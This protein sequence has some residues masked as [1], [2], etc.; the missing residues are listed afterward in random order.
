MPIKII[1]IVILIFAIINGLIFSLLNYFKVK[2]GFLGLNQVGF[3]IF[4][5]LLGTLMFPF[6]FY[7]LVTRSWDMSHLV[8]N[9]NNYF[10]SDGDNDVY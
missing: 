9:D 8:D 10:D 3:F 2:E 1:I 7:R 5:L 4:L 6:T